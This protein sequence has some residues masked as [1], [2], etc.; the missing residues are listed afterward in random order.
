[1]NNYY[2]QF[3]RRIEQKIPTL[4]HLK[5]KRSGYRILLDRQAQYARDD[6]YAFSK[7]TVFLIKIKSYSKIRSNIFL[8]FHY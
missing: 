7:I 1:M 6:E 5:L 3:K 4:K 8:I 2:L